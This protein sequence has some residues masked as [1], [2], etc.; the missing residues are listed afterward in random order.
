MAT[1]PRRAL[2]VGPS[3]APAPQ[4]GPNEYAWR[5]YFASGCKP[6]S[7]DRRSLGLGGKALWARIRGGAS[8]RAVQ[9]DGWYDA[10]AAR[11]AIPRGAVRGQLGQINMLGRPGQGRKTKTYYK[12]ALANVRPYYGESIHY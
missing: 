3:S 11:E 7:E 9:A 12:P 8:P 4:C 2:K 5:N 10:A 6:K 1:S